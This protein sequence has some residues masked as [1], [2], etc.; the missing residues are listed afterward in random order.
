MVWRIEYYDPSAKR[1][2]TLFWFEGS[3]AQSLVDALAFSENKR[4]RATQY[5]EVEGTQVKNLLAKADYRK[6]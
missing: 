3:D 4:Y 2:L 1:W 6:G 5:A